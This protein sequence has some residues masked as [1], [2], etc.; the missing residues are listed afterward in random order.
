MNPVV[1]ADLPSIRGAELSSAAADAGGGGTSSDHETL[2]AL[3]EAPLVI[4]VVDRAGCCTSVQGG[5][6]IDLGV[7]G[8][9]AVGRPAVQ[10]LA[11][12]PGLL[13]AIGQAAQGQEICDAVELLGRQHHVWACPAPEGTVRVV[14]VDTGLPGG[15]AAGPLGRLAVRSLLL[16]RLSMALSRLSRNGGQVV[17]LAV[18]LDRFGPVNEAIGHDAGDLVLAK[19][20]LRLMRVLRS[21][22]TVVRGGGDEFILV[23]ETV[24]S[25]HAVIVLADRVADAI[26]RPVSVGTGEVFLTASIG[27]ACATPESTA[28]DLLAQAESARNEAARGG[29]NGWELFDPASRASV[30]EL[31]E[32][33]QSLHRAVEREQLRLVYQPIIDLVTGDVTGLEALLRWDHPVHRMSPAQFI[34]IAEETGLIIPIGRW[35]LEQVIRDWADWSP[36][37]DRAAPLAIAVNVSARQLR[38]DFADVVQ[39]LLSP[40]IIQ[41]QSWRLSVELTES[42]LADEPE[43]SLQALNTLRFVGLGVI[44]DDFGT[45][46]SSLA[47][48]RRIPLDGI[49]IDRSFVERIETDSADRSLTETV[50][51]LAHSL[52][53]P[54]IAEGVETTGQASILGDLGCDHAQG[55]LFSVPLSA[56]DAAALLTRRPSNARP[57]RPQ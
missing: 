38:G 56:E 8:E 2:A 26:R 30:R 6:C 28:R 35:V 22:D 25:P 19:M 41:G 27:I 14:V 12:L 18:D 43:D 23:C 1:A 5:A 32:A 50:I 48:I 51:R 21:S 36:P 33:E 4:L 39:A 42:C 46:Y 31:A 10:A 55:F 9:A 53:V 45:G 40:E 24:A 3:A 54:A 11:H 29:G 57:G 7:H 47:R 52:G 16:D 17:V 34:P 37:P 44:I 15:E 49:K 20:A 13:A